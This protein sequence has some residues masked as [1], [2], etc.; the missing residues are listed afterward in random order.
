LIDG[1]DGEYLPD[2]LTDEV[3]QFIGT[4]R[5]V[6]FLACLAFYTVHTPIQASRR[7]ID[8]YK[9]KAS[10]LEYADTIHHI[11]ERNGI[12]KLKQDNPAY[13]SM[14][15]AMDENF[16][17]LI[18]ALDSMG[19]G[20][21]TWIIFTSDNGGLS[22]LG[23]PGAP[24][25]NQPLRA[26]KGWCYEGGLRVP[27]IIAGPGISRDGAV[28]DHPVISNDLFK[29]VLEMSGIDL[30]KGM[31]EDGI[32]LQPFFRKTGF[33]PERKDLFWHFP[34]YHGST[35]APG[36]AVRSGDWKLIRFYEEGISELY[37]L[38]EDPGETNNLAESHP[39]KARELESKL[40]RWLEEV[41]AQMAVKND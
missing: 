39:E 30:W 33:L 29:T 25:S 10:Q 11:V 18:R 38:A 24:T 19:I 8:Y 6:P 21:K 7:H 12:T 22:T 40:D 16:G 20:D 23:R 3:I 36:S 17:R 2:R 34:H 26:G 15:H 5:E 9:N 32:S 14:V 27:L 1:P 37:N 41:D 4:N 28:S 13:A 31:P 35:W